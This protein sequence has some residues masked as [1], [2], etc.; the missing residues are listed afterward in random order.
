M[1]HWLAVILIVVFAGLLLWY[2]GWE[3]ISAQQAI[4]ETVDGNSPEG[5]YIYCPECYFESGV[6]SE[7]KF[8]VEK[9]NRRC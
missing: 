8:I 5:F 9:W 4:L 3:Y 2:M 1:K 6:Y 7:P